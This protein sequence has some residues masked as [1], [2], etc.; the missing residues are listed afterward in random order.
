MRI[1]FSGAPAQLSCLV[2]SCSSNQNVKINVS[3]PVIGAARECAERSRL[4]LDPDHAVVPIIL[5][6]SQRNVSRGN[7]SVPR[8]HSRR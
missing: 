7:M 4:V 1:D 6:T 2:C 5:A 3:F 8:V